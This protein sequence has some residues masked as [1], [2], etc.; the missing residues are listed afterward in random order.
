M[1]CIAGDS[2]PIDEERPWPLACFSFLDGGHG[3]G[4]DRGFETTRSRCMESY[5]MFRDVPVCGYVLK[6]GVVCPVVCLAFFL[7]E[8][9]PV[10]TSQAVMEQLSMFKSVMVIASR[11]LCRL[12]VTALQQLACV[13]ILS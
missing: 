7:N 5:V 8:L 10:E 9:P 6:C 1:G 4:L 12:E 3:K 2:R 11:S 13:C